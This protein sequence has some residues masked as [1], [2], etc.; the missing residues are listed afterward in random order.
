MSLRASGRGNARSL[1]SLP[2]VAAAAGTNGAAASKNCPA[3]TAPN[4]LSTPRRHTRSDQ[5][6]LLQVIKLTSTAKEKRI[7]L[8]PLGTAK[9]TVFVYQLLDST[10]FFSAPADRAFRQLTKLSA[11]VTSIESGAPRAHSHTQQN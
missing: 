10:R 7:E 5:Q 4:V 6:V 2:A 8:A 11:E 3:A 9:N 1:L